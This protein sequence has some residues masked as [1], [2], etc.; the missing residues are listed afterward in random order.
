MYVTTG[1]A[2]IYHSRGKSLIRSNNFAGV[3]R[4][5]SFARGWGQAR[6]ILRDYYNTVLLH[7][8]L[9]LTV[10][11]IRHE[12]D[13]N[14]SISSLPWKIFFCALFECITFMSPY[15]EFEYSEN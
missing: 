6:R 9:S 5:F 7:D 15:S 2:F 12:R 3:A 1:V 13:S 10:E 8:D 11:I 4:V 14:I